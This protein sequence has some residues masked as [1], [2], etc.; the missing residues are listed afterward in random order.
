MYIADLLLTAQS[1]QKSSNAGHDGQ[2]SSTPRVHAAYEVNDCPKLHPLDR[3]ADGPGWDGGDGGERRITL[4]RGGTHPPGPWDLTTTCISAA[5]GTQHVSV[6]SHA[7]DRLQPDRFKHQR[8]PLSLYDSRP[9][10]STV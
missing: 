6:C 5:Q 2:K 3:A 7:V 8:W 4:A 1:L 10:R 9:G